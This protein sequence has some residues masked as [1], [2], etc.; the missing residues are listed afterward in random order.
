MSILLFGAKKS[1]LFAF[2]NF[3]LCITV[4]LFLAFE[5]LLLLMLMVVSIIWFGMGDMNEALMIALYKVEL[6]AVNFLG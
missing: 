2:V 6:K 3:G 1:S 5:L 4:F